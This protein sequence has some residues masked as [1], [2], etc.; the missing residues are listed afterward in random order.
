MRNIKFIIITG[1]AFI[2]AITVS[3]IIGTVVNALIPNP[4]KPDPPGVLEPS[5]ED[6][7]KTESKQQQAKDIPAETT[8]T[9]PKIEPTSEPEPAPAQT[10]EPAQTPAP[11]P[12][13]APVSRPNPAPPAPTLGPG[14]FDAP[15][16]P[17]A[18]PAF[19]T[20]PGNM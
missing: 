7:L 6:R 1:V 17:P 4:N 16:P 15:A 14:N 5:L 20:G 18:P 10:P 12:R 19:R 9:E 11:A 13:P 8:E 3:S 2:F